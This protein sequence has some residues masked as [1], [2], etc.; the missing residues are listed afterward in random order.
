MVHV[1]YSASIKPGRSLVSK[2]AIDFIMSPSILRTGVPSS[3]IT[4]SWRVDE[5]DED[6]VLTD[7][8]VIEPSEISS[9]RTILRAPTGSES[10][11]SMSIDVRPAA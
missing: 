8:T 2:I 5:S 1:P 4:E 9:E 11:P 6:P 3:L 7:R 10:T